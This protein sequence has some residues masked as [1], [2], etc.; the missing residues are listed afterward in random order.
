MSISTVRR[1][2]SSS[3]CTRTGRGRTPKRG[4]RTRRTRYPNVVVA[5]WA[6]L[7]DQNPQWFGA[8]G[9]HLAVDGPG[10]DALASLVART[11]SNG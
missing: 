7:A 4:P 6:T 5:D 8:D 2:W 11:L 10:A 1:G 3:T 9:T